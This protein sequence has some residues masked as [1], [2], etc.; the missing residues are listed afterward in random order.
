MKKKYLAVSIIAI[1]IIAVTGYIFLGPTKENVFKNQELKQILIQRTIVVGTEATYPPMEF[2][3][4]QG[5]FAGLDIDIAHE[6][7]SDLGVRAEF[8]NIAWE[9]I[10]D[11]LL[12]GKVDMLISAITITPERLERMEFSDPY[13]NAG[14]VI[15]TT[16][17][18]LNGIKGTEDLTGKK[19]G[20]QIDTTS[21]AEALKYTDTGLVIAYENY[22]LA[23]EDL[24]MGA[25]DAIII[26]YPAGVGMVLKQKDF[27]IIG[28]PFTQEFYGIAVRKDETELLKHINGTIRQLKREGT[29]E[30]LIE[31][32]FAE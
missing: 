7:A 31:K 21:H 5:N 14:Q 19:L 29:I 32:W 22:D 8:Q 24:L 23:A 12:E 4:E 20:V 28:E 27:K 26:D 18:G 1:A 3:D 15:V 6:I 11:A 17:D 2:L 9:K 30:K 10:F 16:T 25:I 13:F